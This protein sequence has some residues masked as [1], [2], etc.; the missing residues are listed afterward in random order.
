MSPQTSYRCDIIVVT[1]NKLDYIRECVASV[2]KHTDVKSRLIVVDNASNADTQN[3]LKGVRGNERVD[4]KLIFNETNLGPGKAR[5]IA[6][7]QMDADY[8]CFVDSDVTV[9]PGW[10]S[11][12]IGL[13]QA[14]TE[15]GMVNPSSNNFNQVPPQGIP[16]DEYAQTLAPLKNSYIEVGQCISFCML[17]K[18][19]VVSEIGLIDEN[20]I[21]AMYEDTDYSMKASA[22]GYRCVI[23]KSAYVWHYGHGSTGRVKKMEAISEKNK[24]RFYKKWGKPLRIIWCSTAGVDD[25]AFK[26]LLG[27]AVKLAREGNFVYFFT[28]EKGLHDKSEVF[29]RAGLTEHANVHLNL[30]K[31]SLFKWFCLWRVLK[32]RKKKYDMA[33][34]DDNGTAAL[35]KQFN[36]LHRAKVIAGSDFKLIHATSQQ[37]RFEGV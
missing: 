3:Y 8:V 19:E 27:A 20:Y 31:G 23:A 35:I 30:Y 2:L 1:W 9:T 17:I 5:N 18:R 32:K 12:M 28:Q 6:L 33:V 36:F 37:K 29:K 15:I 16:L 21:L 22:S 13:A 24:G 11:N 7:R 34:T 4:V 25:R 26:E 10:L 14:Y